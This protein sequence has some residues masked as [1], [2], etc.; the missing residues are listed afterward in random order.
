MRIDKEYEEE[1]SIRD[2]F[3]HVL[4]H[5]RS[6]FL[7]ALF[8]GVLLVSFQFGKTLLSDQKVINQQYEL[9][10]QAYEASVA[11]IEKQ[12]SGNKAE[13]AVL[14]SYQEGSILMRID[15][16]LEW[17]SI[18]AHFIRADQASDAIM[19]MISS[20]LL[21]ME[22]NVA[23]RFF[24]TNDPEY[25]REVLQVEADYDA[26]VMT[27][28]VLGD[29]EDRVRKASNYLLEQIA[30]L[31]GELEKE[32]N[33][34]ELILIREEV[35]NTQDEN[36]A[37][38]QKALAEKIDTTKKNIDT[39]EQALLELQ[40]EAP[41][42]PG[43]GL[44]KSALIGFFVGFFLLVVFHTFYYALNGRIKRSAEIE[45][46]YH[47]KLRFDLFRSRA[48][49]PKH[50]PDKWIERWERRNNIWNDEKLLP[51]TVDLISRDLKSVE[52]VIISTESSGIIDKTARQIAEML[53]E[54][55]SVRIVLNYADHLAEEN[56]K[57]GQI[58]VIEQKHLSRRQNVD[59][60]MRSIAANPDKEVVGI[61]ML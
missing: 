59:T 29:S 48:R 57:G 53:K 50:I 30:E 27:I 5:W 38:N 2:L 6:I 7:F 43:R 3:F 44:A 55:V 15:P 10:L 61:I 25:L 33:P 56:T 22:P 1:I 16:L 21:K 9:D 31:Q 47:L 12:L 18:T 19:I 40:S 46:H 34:F 11:D 32:F 28:T 39:M 36:L 14:E 23:E 49:N 54:N 35:L 51:G 60:V 45:D 37:A 58:L 20:M 41:K 42:K 8:G 13:L 24:G 17:R 4:Y 52:T 26:D